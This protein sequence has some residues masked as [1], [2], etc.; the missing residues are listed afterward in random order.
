MRERERERERLITF[1]M[2]KNVY[3]MGDRL[4]YL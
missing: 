4:S 1:F 3:R 2:W